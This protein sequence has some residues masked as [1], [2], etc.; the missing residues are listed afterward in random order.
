[1]SS[2]ATGPRSDAGK[3]RSSL[4]AVKHGLRSERP[5]IPGEDPV[6]WDAFHADPEWKS[7]SKESEK[8]GKIVKSV[9]SVYMD[10]TD[11]SAIK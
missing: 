2:H 5:V 4:N 1:M 10:P 7:V 8:D 3:E 9:T 11:Y 6:E